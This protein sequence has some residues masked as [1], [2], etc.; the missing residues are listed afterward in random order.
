MQ[1][2]ATLISTVLLFSTTSTQTS[3]RDSCGPN[4]QVISEKTLAHG[5]KEIKFTTTS[6]P[7]F[8][9][10]RNT[11][12][13]P[14]TVHKRQ[15]SQCGTTCNSFLCDQSV[16]QPVVTDCDALT[17]ALIGLNVVFASAPQSVTQ[18]TDGTCFYEYANFDT[19]TYDV[20]STAFG[21]L[22]ESVVTHCF[23]TLPGAV[24]TAGFCLSP[25]VPGNDFVVESGHV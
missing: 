9:A 16:A 7:G 15:V 21:L 8:A 13:T 23:V 11:T 19:V 25:Q 17:T 22:G 20:C 4:A 12:S 24:F 10:L 3:V 6:C 5:D 14:S 2:L 18:V 1:L